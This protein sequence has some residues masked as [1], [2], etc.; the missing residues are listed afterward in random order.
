MAL[1]QVGLLRR[2][3][4]DRH[5]RLAHRQVQFAHRPAAALTVTSG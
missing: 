3:H 1:H 5:V 2:M 4:A